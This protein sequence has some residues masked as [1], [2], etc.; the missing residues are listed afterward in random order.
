M[1][2]GGHHR[3]VAEAAAHI[4]GRVY[5]T[6]SPDPYP[7]HLYERAGLDLAA[8]AEHVDEFV[9]PLYDMYFEDVLIDLRGQTDLRRVAM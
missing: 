8:L 5:L 4:P 1:A 7:G 2:R 3:F 6:L 9:I